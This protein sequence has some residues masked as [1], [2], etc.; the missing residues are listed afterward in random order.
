MQNLEFFKLSGKPHMISKA[1]DNLTEYR[2]MLLH[3]FR[4]NNTKLLSVYCE[5]S[6]CVFRPQSHV[7]FIIWVS[8]ILKDGC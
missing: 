3:D 4:V 7:T 1:V 6:A 2:K 8:A 5:A